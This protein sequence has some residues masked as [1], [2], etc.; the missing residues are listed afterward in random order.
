M[1]LA[2]SFKPDN[3]FRFLVVVPT[4]TVKDNYQPSG[5]IKNYF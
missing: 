2:C 1:L 5:L 4:K 3:I